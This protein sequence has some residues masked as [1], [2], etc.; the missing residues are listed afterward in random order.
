M[1]L[2]K[3]ITLISVYVLWSVPVLCLNWCGQTTSI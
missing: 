2:F 3:N 1:L